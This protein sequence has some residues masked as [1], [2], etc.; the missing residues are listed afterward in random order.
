[1]ILFFIGFYSLQVYIS[2]FKI[3]TKLGFQHQVQKKKR[4]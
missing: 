1:M 4:D 3:Q 2:Q